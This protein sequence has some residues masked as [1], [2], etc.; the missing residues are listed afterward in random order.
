M[1]LLGSSDSFWVLLGSFRIYW[2]SL[3]LYLQLIKMIYHTFFICS[4]V[5]APNTN[6]AICPEAPDVE[7]Q[8]VGGAGPRVRIQCMQGEEE[9]LEDPGHAQGLWMTAWHFAPPNRWVDSGQ[10]G[11]L[12]KNKIICLKII[13]HFRRGHSR[14]VQPVAADGAKRNNIQ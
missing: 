10:C 14:R 2:A 11:H 3:G 4:F 6:A 7:T 5:V 9:L 8:K 13:K 12:H 1:V